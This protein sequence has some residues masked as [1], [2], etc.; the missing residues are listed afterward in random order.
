MK[1]RVDKLLADQG[2]ARSRT[3]AQAL[4]MAGQICVGDKLVSKPSE[5]YSTE[6]KFRLKEGAADKYVSRG[7][8]KLEG[9]LLETKL[10]LKG[11]E[12]LDIGISTGGFP[13][14]FLHRE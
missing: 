2:V 4:I 3:H 8:E 5:E 7:G 11:I 12:T 1:E 14:C 10:D 6:T 13:D 9:A